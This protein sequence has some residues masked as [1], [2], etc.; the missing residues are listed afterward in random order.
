MSRKRKVLL[1]FLIL[2][3]I[4]SNGSANAAG[5]EIHAGEPVCQ[6]GRIEIPVTTDV[7]DIDTEGKYLS[8]HIY[9]QDDLICFENER[10]PLHSGKLESLIIIDPKNNPEIAGLSQIEIQFDIVDEVAAKW[11][12]ADNEATIKQN[13]TIIDMQKMS[14]MI[15]DNLQVEAM[16]KRVLFAFSV[17]INCIGWILVA[18]IAVKV[19]KNF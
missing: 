16:K 9:S 17:L 7:S 13:R 6:H 11:L 19:K 12:L 14:Q 10:Y 4:F 1:T 3:F 15:A 5:I 2:F 18:V 8:Y